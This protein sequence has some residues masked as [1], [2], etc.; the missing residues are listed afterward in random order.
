MKG[1]EQRMANPFFH[2]LALSLALSVAHA[3]SQRPSL[4]IS[5]ISEKVFLELTIA[6]ITHVITWVM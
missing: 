3:Q 2:A 4:Q 5:N 6:R 1:D